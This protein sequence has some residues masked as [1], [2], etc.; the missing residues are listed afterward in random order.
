M[1]RPVLARRT[2][3]RGAH[4][5]RPL[6]SDGT[7]GSLWDCL[8][9]H[10]FMCSLETTHTGRPSSPRGPSLTTQKLLRELL[11]AVGMPCRSPWRGSQSLS[12]LQAGP[13]PCSGGA[14][15]SPSPAGPLC[16]EWRRPE[17]SRP[18]FQLQR[19]P[20]GLCGA[21]SAGEGEQPSSARRGEGRA[22]GGVPGCP[23]PVPSGTPNMPGSHRLGKLSF[24][25]HRGRPRCTD[26]PT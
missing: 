16:A 6:P 9:V 1:R 20:H 12:A 13:G 19:G 15:V 14:G 7:G 11:V 2:P 5:R 17:A 22:E 25:K 23:S 10:S 4:A 18:G 21:A 26:Q 8:S 24:L 3:L